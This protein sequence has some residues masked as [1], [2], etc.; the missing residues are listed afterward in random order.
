MS[1]SDKVS[2][3]DACKAFLKA[4]TDYQMATRDMN[5]ALVR[6]SDRTRDVY[7]SLNRIVTATKPATSPLR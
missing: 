2:L 6:I 1:R 7:G 5:L 4:L 3:G